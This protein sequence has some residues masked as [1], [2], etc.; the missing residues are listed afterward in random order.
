MS[1]HL[2]TVPEKR[3]AC[4]S[5]GKLAVTHEAQPHTEFH[6]CP[7]LG[8]LAPMVEIHGNELDPMSARHRLVDR[9]DY[10]GDEMCRTDDHGRPWMAIAT[11]R[12]DGSND[13]AVFAPTAS[14]RS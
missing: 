8:I 1:A 10:V 3:W 11:D 13:L 14:N 4:P 12:A 2:L 7:A 5:C 6:H 9:E